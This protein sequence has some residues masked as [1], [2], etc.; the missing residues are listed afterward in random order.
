MTSEPAQ[1]SSPGAPGRARSAASGRQWALDAL[2][3]GSVV[4]VVAIHVFAGMVANPDVRGTAG[5]WGAVVADIGFVWVVPVFVMISGALVLA[6]RQH[7]GGP[8]LF[9]RKR[10]PRLLT[11]LVFWSLLYFVLIRT[12]FSQIAPTRLD[13]ARF[14]LD[15]QPY[16][17]LYFLWLIVGLYVVAPVLAS[18]LQGG[19]QRR[20]VIFA[21][22]TLGATVVTGV[23]S[24]VLTAMGDA[25]PLTLLALTQ[26]LP[27]AGYFL[28]GWALRAVRVSGWRF[29]VVLGLTVLAIVASIVQYGLRPSLPLV[30]AVLP[31]S[32]FGPVVAAAS[33]GVFICVNSALGRWNPGPGAQRMVRELSD[34]A[35]GV[36]LVHFAIMLLVRALPPFESAAGSLLLSVLEWLVVVCSSFLVVFLMRRVPGL[37]RVV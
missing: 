1:E 27:Y 25:A 13:L 28:A 34:C 2:R 15:G 11:A 24:S 30:D 17:H 22:V 23:S 20:A 26:W 36:F 12:L 14:V 16:T 19:G 33:L 3:I 31:L 10:L 18:F 8:A 6:P 7:A 9:Y 29:V 37:R 4:G 35:F 21:A 5:W 32:Y